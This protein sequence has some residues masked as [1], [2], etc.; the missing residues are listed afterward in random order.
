[1][2]RKQHQRRVYG[3]RSGRLFHAPGSSTTVTVH[4]GARV[5]GPIFLDGGD[6][7][8][9]QAGG[10]INSGLTTVGVISNDGSQVNN[11]GTITAVGGGSNTGIIG[12][13]S[14]PIANSGTIHV[15]GSDQGMG[16]QAGGN[17]VR[18][19]NSGAIQATGGIGGQG[20]ITTG[21]NTAQVTNSGSIT[22]GGLD[23][24]MGLLVQGGT[25]AQAAN[26][27]T[28]EAGGAAIS[29]GM[30]VI[31]GMTT[32]ATNSGTIQAS[33]ALFGVGLMA[34]GTT[35]QMDNSGTI[36]T[37]S[38]LMGIGIMA[39]GGMDHAQISN[40]GTITTNGSTQAIGM[41][42]ESLTSQVVNSGTIDAS[43]ATMG[44]GLTVASMS[45]EIVNSGTISGTTAS[46]WGQYGIQNVTNSGT[47]N[48]DVWLMDGGDAFNAAGG[49]VNGTID[50]GDG[51]DV[52]NFTM[53]ISA[54]SWESAL[55]TLRETLD[56]N[57]GSIVLGG[58]TYTWSNFEELQSLIRLLSFHDRRLNDLDFAATAIVYRLAAGGVELY[59][60]EGGWVFD[61]DAD[62]L[63]AAL[64]EFRRQRR[65]RRSRLPAG[66]RALRPAGRLPA[67]LRPWRLYLHLRALPL[68][69][70]RL[71]F[72][73]AHIRWDE[74]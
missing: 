50:G 55:A 74:S 72:P 45:S 52:L 17:D 30:Q 42:V 37:S 66:D 16:I 6:T 14:G 39:M 31:S 44:V 36:D 69:N 11:A 67:G 9:V 64:A 57:G 22:A 63:I 41:I 28:I 49:M 51:Y 40:S 26:S 15:D 35:L 4:E 47:L 32:Q 19:A 27:G 1:M 54:D 65:A 18:V 68:R 53:D 59:T 25:T 3:R 12:M 2:R 56:P 58:I 62:A 13:N 60:P 10:S 20:I 8:N 43:S 5:N 71:A 73:P 48:G 24:G 29:I 7:L 21:T 70:R 46:L 34:Q 23:A 38:G 33:G 61:A